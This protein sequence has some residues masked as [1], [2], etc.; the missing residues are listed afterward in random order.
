MHKRKQADT[1]EKRASNK[2]HFMQRPE[3]DRQ[4]DHCVQAQITFTRRN[5]NV[6]KGN[7]ADV[8]GISLFFL[9]QHHT[10]QHAQTDA[11]RRS[12][13]QNNNQKTC[14]ITVHY[15]NTVTNQTTLHTRYDHSS[16]QTNQCRTPLCQRCVT[17]EDYHV[18]V[19]AIMQRITI[20]RV[21]SGAKFASICAQMNKSQSFKIKPNV[22]DEY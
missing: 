9:A 6:Q 7:H 21:P 17:S 5:A 11:N 10:T 16:H 19:H 15:A 8:L 2:G 20:G 4:Q 13:G 22:H 18:S 14:C 12:N 3:G 1:Y